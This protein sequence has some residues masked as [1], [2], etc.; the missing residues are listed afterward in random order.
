MKKSS[1][2]I[3][4]RFDVYRVRGVSLTKTDSLTLI[5]CLGFFYFDILSLIK[6]KN[7]LG[8]RVSFDFPASACGFL[9]SSRLYIAWG[10]LF[11]KVFP[12]R[13]ALPYLALTVVLP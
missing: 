13:G 6:K 7:I 5:L 3:S 11:L 10:I 12:G 9:S 8:F 1:K 4:C 2:Q